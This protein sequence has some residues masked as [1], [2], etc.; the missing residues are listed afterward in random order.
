MIGAYNIIYD[1]H[2]RIRRYSFGESVKNEEK[3][4]KKIGNRPGSM[5]NK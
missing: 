1:G 2:A 4:M 5:V 3:K